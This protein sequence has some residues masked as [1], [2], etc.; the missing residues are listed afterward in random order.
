MPVELWVIPVTERRGKTRLAVEQNNSNSLHIINTSISQSPGPSEAPTF[1]FWFRSSA[2]VEEGVIS[3]KRLT[4]WPLAFLP[5]PLLP[6]CPPRPVFS[7]R[8]RSVWSS[9]QP[10]GSWGEHIKMPQSIRDSL[11]PPSPTS[12]K[13]LS[14]ST[15][16][17]WLVNIWIPTPHSNSVKKSS[18]PLVSARPTPRR[19]S[20]PVIIKGRFPESNQAAAICVFEILISGKQMARRWR[21]QVEMMKYKKG[22]KARRRGGTRGKCLWC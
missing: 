13:H 6:P 12:P 17:W 3:K 19:A 11:L 21:E 16:R 18:F 15:A 20:P 10:G 2:G 9:R 4:L 5:P 1:T 22:K 7:R 8:W 14:W